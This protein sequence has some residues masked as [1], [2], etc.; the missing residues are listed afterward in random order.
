MKLEFR[1]SL[2]CSKTSRRGRAKNPRDGGATCGAWAEAVSVNVKR[3]AIETI[4]VGIQDLCLRPR[5][6]TR[7]EAV[8]E[9]FEQD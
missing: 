6:E 8:A 7:V 2:K 9:V 5:L 4:D 3:D 1:L